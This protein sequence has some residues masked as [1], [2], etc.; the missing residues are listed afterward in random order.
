MR[1]DRFSA[2]LGSG[3]WP[4]SVRNTLRRRAARFFSRRRCCADTDNAQQH[5]H[6]AKNML[7]L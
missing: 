3:D 5:I 4:L 1:A 2:L 6:K 7:L